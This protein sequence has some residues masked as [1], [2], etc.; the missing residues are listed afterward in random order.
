ML[1]Y[2]K[3]NVRR[4]RVRNPV[5]KTEHSRGV[6]NPWCSRLSLMGGWVT[7]KKLVVFHKAVLENGMR[8]NDE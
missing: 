2:Q 6:G 7:V 3:C 8:C 5:P 1:P 4:V